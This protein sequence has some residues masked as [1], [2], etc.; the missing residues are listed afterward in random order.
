MDFQEKL[1]TDGVGLSCDYVRYGVTHYFG[2]VFIQTG[3]WVIF[4][5]RDTG[6]RLILNF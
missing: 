3:S 1:E 2:R 4:E 5:G 6:S